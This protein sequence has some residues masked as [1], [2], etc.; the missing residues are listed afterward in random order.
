MLIYLCR[1]D[2]LPTTRRFS[3]VSKRLSMD[4]GDGVAIYNPRQRILKGTGFKSGLSPTLSLLLGLEASYLKEACGIE[5]TSAGA[6]NGTGDRPTS[7]RSPSLCFLP[8]LE[9]IAGGGAGPCCARPTRASFSAH[10]CFSQTRGCWEIP[11]AAVER[12]HSDRARSGSRGISQQR[13]Y[14]F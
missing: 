10:L 13:R 14:H 4:S 3:V 2:R 9:G 6:Q 1:S 12:A 11:I 5:R 7:G 8:G